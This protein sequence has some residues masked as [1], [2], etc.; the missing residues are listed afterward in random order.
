MALPILDAEGYA[1]CPD[2]DSHVNC[3]TIGLANLE[4]CHRGKKICKAAQ[5]K[6]D[7]EVKLFVL[8]GSLNGVLECK[9]AGCET[10]IIYNV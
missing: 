10:H 1:I 7:K 3:G 2:C 4:K 8:D 9:Q 6:Q 5:Q